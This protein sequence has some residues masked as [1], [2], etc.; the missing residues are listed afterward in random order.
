MPKAALEI[1]RVPPATEQGAST[2]YTE[3]SLDG[4]RPGIYWINLRDT[5]ESPFWFMPTT[6]FHEGIGSHQPA[7]NGGRRRAQPRAAVRP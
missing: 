3:G 2:H 1:R 7:H 5:A 6:T 4:S